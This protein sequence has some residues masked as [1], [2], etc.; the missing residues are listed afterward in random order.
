MTAT[1]T[2]KQADALDWLRNRPQRCATQADATRHGYSR[3][4]FLALER[5]GVVKQVHVSF[6]G[7][8]KWVAL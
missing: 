1:F 4:I 5:K 3:S 8:D 7:V 2:V 6:I